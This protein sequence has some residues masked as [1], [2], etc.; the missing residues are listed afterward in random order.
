MTESERRDARAQ[1]LQALSA[2]KRGSLQVA[3]DYTRDTIAE[4]IARA[5]NPELRRERFTRS[6]TVLRAKER[7]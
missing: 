2:L 1:Y 7:A 5:S 3:N 4:A 6:Y